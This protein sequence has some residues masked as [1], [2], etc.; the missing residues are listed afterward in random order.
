MLPG[1]MEV[2]NYERENVMDL[3]VN[4]RKSNRKIENALNFAESTVP[5]DF[6]ST[7]VTGI[8]V[9]VVERLREYYGLERRPVKVHEPYQMLG[10]IEEDLQNAIGSDTEGVFGRNTFFGFPLDG[11]WKEFKTPWGQQVLVPQNFNTSQDSSGNL[12]IYPQGDKSAKASG[13]MPSK[14]YFFD[15]IIR[16]DP[17]FESNL[18]PEQNLEE[19][20]EISEQDLQY[21]SE[22]VIRASNKGRA[23]VATLGGTAIGDIAQVPGPSLK[24]PKGIRDITE[25][26]VSTLMRQD[27]LH[28]V[29]SR[30]VE[31]AI[32]NLEKINE[33]VGNLIDVVFICGT[34]FGT[35]NSAFC[36]LETYDTLY[37]PYYKK[38][39]GWIHDHTAW[40]TFK[41]SCGAVKEFIPRFIDSGFD[42]L[43]P[44]QVSAA[45]M[46]P[47]KIKDSFGKDIVFWGGGVDT[48]KTL[49]FGTAP[50]VREQ[51]L[52][53]C[54]IFSRDGGF[55]FTTIHNIQAKTPLENVIA[56][57]DAVKEYNGVNK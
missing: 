32:H 15:S 38:I 48:Q 18:N 54:E 37:A 4:Q 2:C 12:L 28:A 53:H 51:V 31:I 14:G 13:K 8:H 50:E 17:D 47:E 24:K 25:W 45:G 1:Q 29:F 36:S 39:N 16:Q 10:L 30:Q 19:F 20:T 52:R 11:D 33:R 35:Q 6:G 23:V 42:I 41:H 43:N 34:D 7:F 57:I 55:V 9:S 22:E 49:P 26:Y 5:I 44:V 40:K 56:M 21:I 27:Y 46:E 3:T